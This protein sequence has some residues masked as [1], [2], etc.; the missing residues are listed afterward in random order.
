[1][2]RGKI[3]GRLVEGIQAAQARD[4]RVSIELICNLPNQSWAEI[5][6]DLERAITLD[7]D[8]ISLYPWHAMTV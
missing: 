6:N 4:F 7:I 1:M 3:N 8:Q 2:G 5:K